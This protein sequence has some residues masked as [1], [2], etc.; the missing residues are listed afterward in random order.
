[1][2][3]AHFTSG[4]SGYNFI[5][6]PLDPSIYDVDIEVIKRML[7]RENELRKSNDIQ[8]AYK[9]AQKDGFKGFVQVTLMIQKMVNRLLR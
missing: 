6:P 8:I 3:M 9:N 5:R 2:G 7:K 1:M 4:R